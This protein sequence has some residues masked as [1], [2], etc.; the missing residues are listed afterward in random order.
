MMHIGF[1]GDGRWAHRAIESIVETSDL[2]VAYIVARYPNADPILKEWSNELGVP[3]L[4]PKNVNASTFLKRLKEL[5]ADVNVSVSY[6]QILRRE[7]IHVAT[8]GFINCHAGALPFYRGRNILNWALINGEDRFGVTVHYV[9]EG[10]DT[11]DIITQRFGVITPLDTYASLLDQAVEL[12]ADA[13]IDAL[14]KVK[15]DSFSATPQEQIHPVGFYC[16]NR[17]EGDEWIDWSWSTERIYNTIRAL[18]PPGPGARTLHDGHPIVITSAE[19]ILHAP[20]YIDRPGTVV[21]KNAEGIIVK[22]GD[23]S[24]KIT[25]VADWNGSVEHYRTPRHRV[26]TSFGINLLH[27]VNRLRCRVEQLENRISRLETG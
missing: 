27:E 6:D 14:H 3:F 20:S 16:S 24:L 5:K 12:C 19:K 11:G 7:A 2:G 23:T 26:G 17:R 10:I 25:E 22:T 15:D 21:G 9:D 4:A 18:V 8:E 1:F 13:L